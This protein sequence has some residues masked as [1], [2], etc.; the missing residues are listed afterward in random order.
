LERAGER[1][2]IKPNENSNYKLR[3][4][5]YKIPINRN[6]ILQSNLLGDD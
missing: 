5:F 4:F 3:E 6:A 2:K 1:K